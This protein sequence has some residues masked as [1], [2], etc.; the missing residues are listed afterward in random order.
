MGHGSFFCGHRVFPE[1][2]F[3][4][5]KG[6]TEAFR[7]ASRLYRWFEIGLLLQ[8]L[9]ASVSEASSELRWR[10]RITPALLKSVDAVS[11][12]L[13]SRK[14]PEQLL[15]YHHPSMISHAMVVNHEKLLLCKTRGA[16]NDW[17]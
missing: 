1:V 9:R 3:G 10:R 2:E 12:I 13:L 11:P 8:A 14:I 15:S 16:V 6:V 7:V 17:N 5:K 4:G